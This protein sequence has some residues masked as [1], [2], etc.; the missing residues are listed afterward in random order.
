MRRHCRKQWRQHGQGDSNSDPLQGPPGDGCAGGLT[1]GSLTPV[2]TAGAHCTPLPAGSAGTQRVPPAWGPRLVADAFGAPVLRDQG[3]IGRPTARRLLGTPC[4][5][6]CPARGIPTSIRDRTWREEWTMAQDQQDPLAED[7]PSPPTAA[8][9]DSEF[10]AAD[11]SPGLRRVW[12][13]AAPDLPP[14]PSRQGR[15]WSTWAADAA[16]LGCGSPSRAAPR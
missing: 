3:P 11:R 8:E 10:A 14:S 16:V 6:S 2:V 13:R 12:Q 5:A 1:C 9:F 15:R 7:Q 4:M